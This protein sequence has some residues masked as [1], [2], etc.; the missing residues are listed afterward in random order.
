VPRLLLI[1]LLACPLAAQDVFVP[2]VPEGLARDGK[3]RTPEGPIPFPSAE[4][5]WTRVRSAR[6]DLVSSASEERT[7]EIITTLE[8]LSTA[9]GASERGAPATV[10]L[11][12]NRGESQPYFDLLFNR[13]DSPATGAYVRH[14]GGGTMFIDAS[15]MTRIERTAMHE[16]IHDVLRRQTDTMPPLWLEEGLAEYFST[17]RLEGSRVLAGAP[18]PEH[19]AILRRQTPMTAREMLAVR[20]E[21]PAA[22]SSLFYAQSWVAVDWLLSLGQEKFFRFLEDVERGA[23]VETAL[24]KHFEKTIP[25]LDRAVRRRDYRRTQIV[26]QSEEPPEPVAEPL[27]RSSLLFELGRFLSHV[28]GAEREAKRHFAEAVRVEPTHA[29]SLAALGRFE[30]AI[31]AGPDDPEVHLLYAE[32]L[33]STAIGP[34]AG[35]FEPKPDD[36]D[37]FRKARTL[38]RRALELGGEEGRARGLIGTTYLVETDLAR[39]IAELER[40]RALAP[41]RDDFALNLYTMYLRTGNRARADALFAS[42]FENARDKQT[43][44][45]ARNILLVEETARVNTL[46]ATGALD[47]AAAIVRD[48]AR[49]TP[50]AAARQELERQAVGLEATAAVNRHI[51]T[52]NEAISLVNAGRYREARRVLDALLEVATDA[53]VVR[54]AKALRAEIA[55]K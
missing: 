50:D 16:L 42:A 5:E 31:A 27:S 39:G 23:D 1:L 40:A 36:P 43:A 15:R 4:R 19:A 33:L 48:L 8:A 34:F 10:F 49:M 13:V 53:Q 12:S 47:E 46:A 9:L 28:A 51:G 41:N 29:R 2:P 26:L 44:F 52:Y 32:L 37:K 54:D 14:D 55:K 22:A 17:A 18:V 20:A 24:Q 35:V 38:A 45:A 7:R 6:F 25:D 21:E 30:A 11:F 3:I